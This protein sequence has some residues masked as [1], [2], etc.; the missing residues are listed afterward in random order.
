MSSKRRPELPVSTSTSAPAPLPTQATVSKTQLRKQEKAQHKANR[1]KRA[2]QKA[3]AQADRKA[4][5]QP[6]SDMTVKEAKGVFEMSSKS[7]KWIQSKDC[8]S[9]LNSFGGIDKDKWS[10]CSSCKDD[11]V[12]GCENVGIYSPTEDGARSVVSNRLPTPSPSK[13][14]LLPLLLSQAVFVSIWYLKEFASSILESIK[15]PTLDVRQANRDRVLPPIEQSDLCRC[16]KCTVDI[17]PS[18]GRCGRCEKYWCSKCFAKEKKSGPTCTNK[19][20]HIYVP[21]SFLHRSVADAIISSMDKV[22]PLAKPSPPPESERF[23]RLRS[24][25]PTTPS[26]LASVLPKLQGR[27]DLVRILDSKTATVN[28]EEEIER[29][30][31]LGIPVATNV[32]IGREWELTGRLWDEMRGEAAVWEQN[33]DS[34]G[35]T[36]RVKRQKANR[37]EQSSLFKRKEETG[38]VSTFLGRIGKGFG[39]YLKD[40]PQKGWFREVLPNT[41]Q[42]FEKLLPH[43]ALMS[44]HGILN[45]GS[46]LYDILQPTDLGPKGYF[47]DI[48]ENTVLHGE[49][50]YL[51]MPPDAADACNVATT[52]LTS[53]SW[54]VGKPV[55]IWFLF[56]AADY[57]KIVKVL[58]SKEN[59]HPLQSFEISLTEELLDQLLQSGVRVQLLFQQIGTMVI[60]PAGCAHEVVNIAPVAKFALDFFPASSID[61]CL[62]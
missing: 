23:T 38:S 33:E 26:T 11:A 34:G 59:N 44:F 45:L 6:R 25:P 61:R 27:V 2:D 22:P 1:L 3:A 28:I 41:F 20:Q 31:S 54:F 43:P 39:C 58:Y 62:K 15:S 9:I 47:A 51:P 56:D 36:R 52:H 10:P 16:D 14:P 32:E 12:A 19:Q 42:A 30:I 55:A 40:F 24:L 49:P 50:L 21:L 48:S 4:L 29:H 5:D 46:V 37:K 53:E 35:A 18:G 7:R 17:Y 8:L 60:I 13:L 57:D